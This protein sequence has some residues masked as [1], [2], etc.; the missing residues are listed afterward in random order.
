LGKLKGFKKSPAEIA[1][2][3]LRKMKGRLEFESGVT[4]EGELTKILRHE[5]KNVV[6]TFERCTVKLGDR[7]L[8]DPS[9]GTYDLAC[10]EH[11]ISV[12][13]G[14]PDRGKYLAATGGFAQKPARQKTNLTKEN[15]GLAKLYEKV[16]KV[17]EGGGKDVAELERVHAELERDYPGDW[18]LRMELLETKGPWAAAA[19]KRLDEIARTDKDKAE[20][21]ARGLRSLA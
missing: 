3:E 21:I 17:R 14:P 5:G 8:F 16:R 12:F 4:V 6:L 15:A 2:G 18:L 13:G 1:E 10:G 7:V 9:W 19:R 20:L 11:V